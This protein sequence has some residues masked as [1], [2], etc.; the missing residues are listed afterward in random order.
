M[1]LRIA[2][3]F[4]LIN[5]GY[6]N[7]ATNNDGDSSQVSSINF[8]GLHATAAT[9]IIHFKW[10]VEQENKGD[11]FLIEKS[12]DDINWKKVT[13]VKSLE[14]HKERHTYTISEI[15]FAEGAAEY[16]RIIRVDK[17]GEK[18]ELDKVE[19]NQPILTNMLLLPV[20]GKANKLMS[21][22]YDSLICSDGKITVQNKEG[23]ILLE[24]TVHLSEGYNRMALNIKGF[25]GGRYLVLIKDEF[26]NKISKALTIYR[27]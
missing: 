13:Q 12:I 4:L 18:V 22:S 21:L 26:D 15:N 25:E 27:K 23:D 11:Y 19:I 10:E 3:I 24:K 14:N 17:Y 7:A 8:L 1:T 16:F 5:C 6:L 2:V 20:K 9:K